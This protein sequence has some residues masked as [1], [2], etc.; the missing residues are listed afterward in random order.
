MTLKKMRG[1]NRCPAWKEKKKG[2]LEEKIIW[3]FGARR[4]Y[5]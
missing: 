5:K 2:K 3:W 4:D 1:G